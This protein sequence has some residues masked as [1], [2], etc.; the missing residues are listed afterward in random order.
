M[1]NTTIWALALVA[2][3]MG[4]DA[5]S[6]GGA[7]DAVA[8]AAGGD[9]QADAGK[10]A[11]VKELKATV[12]APWYGEET[13]TFSANVAQECRFLSS[14]QLYVTGSSFTDKGVETIEMRL[15]IY[16]TVDLSTD[17]QT[18]GFEKQPDSGAKV[19]Q[20]KAALRFGY[21]ESGGATINLSY[22]DDGSTVTLTSLDPC[23]GAF[24]A[25]IVALDPNGA[26]ITVE[27]RDGTF[28]IPRSAQ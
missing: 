11:A 7:T 15:G 10:P 17:S 4:C 23:E 16:E 14:G 22:I 8:D 24:S 19:A 20:G 3:A 28:S 26:G 27:L 12:A 6:D 13:G 21:E 5:A 18:F 9:V 25:K 1:R 2:C